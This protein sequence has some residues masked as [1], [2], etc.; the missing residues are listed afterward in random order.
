MPPECGLGCRI[1]HRR[2]A[3]EFCTF[4]ARPVEVFAGQRQILRAGFGKQF[5]AGKLFPL[6]DGGTASRR[7]MDDEER[8]VDE[9]R[10]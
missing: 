7:D 10:Q 1:A 6:D 2:R 3:D 4:H 8:G 5:R 9:F